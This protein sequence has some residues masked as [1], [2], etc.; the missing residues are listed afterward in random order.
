MRAASRQLDDE[1]RIAGR[2]I[3]RRPERRAVA[4]G[5]LGQLG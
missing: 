3:D 5:Q 1:E 2:A 4:C